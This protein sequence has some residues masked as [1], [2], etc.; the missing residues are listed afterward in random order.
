MEMKRKGRRDGR[1]AGTG[2]EE[3]NERA[4]QRGKRRGM[5]SKTP[6]ERMRRPIPVIGGRGGG[7]ERGSHDEGKNETTTHKCHTRNS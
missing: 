6:R 2:W 3:R 5:Y 7:E 4:R 1:S